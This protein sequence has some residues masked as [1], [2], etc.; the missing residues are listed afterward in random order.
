MK[1][2]K[3][4]ASLLLA[5]TLVLTLA[6]SAAAEGETTSTTYKITINNT[7]VGH[8][9]QVYQIFTGTL[10]TNETGGKVLSNVEWGTGVTYT[11]EGVVVGKNDDNTDIKSK[12]ASDIANALSGSTMTLGT[13][14]SDLTLNTAVVEV[15]ST[16]NSTVIENLAPGYYLVKDKDGSVPNNETYTRYIVQVVG[17]ATVN[18]KSAAPSFEKKVMDKNDTTGETSGWQDSADYDIGD[19]VPFQ[20]KGTVASDFKSYKGPYYFA[21]HDV[22]ETGLS[23]DSSSVKVY[24]GGNQISTGYQ[25][26]ASPTDGCTFEVVFSNLKDIESVQAGSVITVEYES[27]LNENAVLGYQGNVNKAKLEFSNNPNVTQNGTTGETNWD[28]VIVFTYKVV[29]NKYANSVAE[30]N[31]LG[32]AAFKLEKK[33]KGDTVDTWSEV[34]EFTVDE[35]NPASSFTFSGLDDGEYRLTETVTPAGY[36]TIDPISFTVSAEHTITWNSEARTAILTSLSGEAASGEIIF[37]PNIPEGSLSADVVNQSGSTLPETGGMGTT[38]FY[39][40]GGILA[41]A[42]IVLLVTKKRMN[43]AE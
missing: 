17:D 5:L 25:V 27:T 16:A 19:K 28:N 14:I 2:M 31:K 40:I 37:T 8:T 34:K 6:I 15:N 39:V 35:Q 30:G 11:G 9:Y 43:S 41:V 23:F 20:L 21:F 26:V 12:E 18:V 13:L 7:T 32:G 3:R 36:N 33:V 29:V 22:E 10:S 24:V 38:L 4:L 42:A 1:H